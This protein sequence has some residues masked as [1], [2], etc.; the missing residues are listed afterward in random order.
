[1]IYASIPTKYKG[2]AFDSRLE[3]RW[4][5]FFDECKWRW[6]YQPF[7][8]KGWSP[9]FSLKIGNVSYLVNVQPTTEDDSHLMD[10][11]CEVTKDR[12]ENTQLL[13]LG[14]HP[15]PSFCRGDDIPVIGWLDQ[16]HSEPGEHAVVVKCQTCFEVTLSED[17]GDWGCRA[18]DN[19]I[20]GADDYVWSGC[21]KCHNA[22]HKRK[23]PCPTCAN[24]GM[25]PTSRGS[26]GCCSSDHRTWG[27]DGVYAAW[28]NATNATTV[29]ARC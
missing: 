16:R 29:G 11:L 5:V 18:C 1:M 26:E 10:Y 12:D 23:T 22:H 20:I 17:W 19:L 25:G 3:A 13:L 21:L 6:T 8:L 7:D 2:I 28:T 15:Q 14:P 4:A 9:H 27:W 24:K